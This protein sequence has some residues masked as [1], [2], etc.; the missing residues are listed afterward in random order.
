MRGL[1]WIA[2][3]AATSLLGCAGSAPMAAPPERPNVVLIIADDMTWHD[4]GAY[5]SEDVPTPNIDRLAREG[6]LFRR[7]FQATAMCAPTRQQ[8]YTGIDPVR[9]GAYPNHAWVREGTQSVFTY[10]KAFGYR[11]GLTGKT[12]IGPRAS[13]P[14]E[15]VGDEEG[16]MS[17]TEDL[18]PV[19]MNAAEAFINRK[20][21][22]PFFLV[23]ASHNPHGPWTNGDPSI[24]DPGTFHVPPYMADT[25]GTRKLMAAYY[26]EITALD[27]EVGQVL[28]MIDKAG[29]AENTIVIFTSEQGSSVPFAKWTLY[30]AGIRTDLIVRWPGHVAAGSST[31]AMVDYDDVAPTLLA[32]AGAPPRPDLDGTSF[33]DVLTGRSDKHRDYI[34]GVHTNTG[35]IA[36][37][38]YPIR[39]VRDG[40]YK[41]I[42][43]LESGNRYL[44]ALNNTQR[45]GWMI[46]DWTAAAKAGNKRAAE[47]IQAYEH[48]PPV[49]LYDLGTDPFE[50]RNQADNPALADVRKRLQARLD[51]WMKQQGDQG[52]ATERQAYDHIN[53]ALLDFIANYD[54]AQPKP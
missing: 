4:S 9:S 21:G 10:L 34:Y 49:E 42:V 39:A 7:A 19:D 18:P 8:I 27:G 25:P 1:R 29:L 47:R 35:I 12:H 26:A 45:G 36:G 3:V 31:D 5:G 52:I 16:G 33:L 41:L 30:D 43:N 28:E 15:Y 44:N 20:D 51:A 14:F 23:V 24:F 17:S 48:R 53:P 50:L 11:V 22:K 38:P 2:A 46:R 6:M 54:K 13:F 32:A 37:D 40:R